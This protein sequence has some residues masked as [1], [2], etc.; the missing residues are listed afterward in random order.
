MKRF[1]N[2]AQTII[3]NE[4]NPYSSVAEIAL[5]IM[6]KSFT[7]E[8]TSPIQRCYATCWI[9]KHEEDLIL[10]KCRRWIQVICHKEHHKEHHKQNH[11]QNHKECHKECHKEEDNN[12]EEN[13]ENV[14]EIPLLKS[15]INFF[16]DSQRNDDPQS[17]I[18]DKVMRET[19]LIDSKKTPFPFP[20]KTNSNQKFTL[21]NLKI[22]KQAFEKTYFQKLEQMKL[23]M[24]DLKKKRNEPDIRIS[25]GDFSEQKREQRR[26]Q[27]TTRR[28]KKKQSN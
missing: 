19:I 27:R 25:F 2:F 24:Q 7:F 16:W 18:I 26:E 10:E 20:P 1:E 14:D 12:N 15:E 11:K 9:E 3:G 6:L 13:D 17:T 23:N 4:N 22:Y 8:D 5:D 28:T 21:F